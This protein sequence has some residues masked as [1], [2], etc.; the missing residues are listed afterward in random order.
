MHLNFSPVVVYDG[1]LDDYRDL[2]REVADTIGDAA[3]RQLACEVIF[4]THSEPMHRV[5]LGWH[6]RAES[7]LWTPDNQEAKVSGRGGHNVRY[8]RGF[9]GER[10]REFTNLLARE[11][12]YC[13]V[14]YAF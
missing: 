1:W 14:R 11:L 4:L 8:R 2:F 6:P 10:V 7:V 9:K 5:N 3:K 12:P 13:R